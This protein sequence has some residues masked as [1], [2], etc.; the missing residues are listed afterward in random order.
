LGQLQHKVI[1]EALMSHHQT[2][3]N[4][5]TSITQQF[6]FQLKHKQTVLWLINQS[7]LS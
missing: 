3:E 6:N 2:N 5:C 7:F 1:F 4:Q